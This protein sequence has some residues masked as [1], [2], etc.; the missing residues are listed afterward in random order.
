M[1]VHASIIKKADLKR[2]SLFAADVSNVFFSTQ[3]SL[4]QIEKKL[5]T[6][7]GNPVCFTT[8]E[9]EHSQIKQT[10]TWKHPKRDY[11]ETD[12]LYVSGI[13]IS[14]INASR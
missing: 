1:E 10:I 3:K 5:M 11:K 6:F 13:K 4:T 2:Y 7:S 12:A 8:L 14:Q 9:I